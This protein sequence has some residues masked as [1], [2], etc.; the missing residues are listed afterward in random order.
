MFIDGDHTGEGVRNDFERF[1]RRVRIGGRCC[2]TMPVVMRPCSARIQLW[3]PLREIVD[4]RPFRLVKSVNRLAHLERIAGGS[5][6]GRYFGAGA[7]G[8]RCSCGFRWTAVPGCGFIPSSPTICAP[9]P[10]F[11][12][13]GGEGFAALRTDAAW[14][15]S[16]LVEQR[17]VGNC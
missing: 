4:E 13:G 3:K 14:G 7:N 12:Q 5:G 17:V 6:A 2:L 1:G 8:R 16:T 10:I 15:V 11:P 9:L